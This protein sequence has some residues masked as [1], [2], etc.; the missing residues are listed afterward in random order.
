MTTEW[1]NL[2]SA[3]EFHVDGDSID[4][5]LAN[6][7]RH[8]ISVRDSGAVY[9]LVSVVA[10]AAALREVPDAALMT[11][12]RNRSAQLVGFRID[13]RGHLV[14][15]TWVPKAGLRAEE[16]QTYVRRLAAECDRFEYLLT[17]RDAD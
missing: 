4:V 15:E 10:H 11:W 14:G 6:E 12:R 1:K 3:K 5:K 13:K 8:R 2:C 17:G 16:F 9:E 7:R